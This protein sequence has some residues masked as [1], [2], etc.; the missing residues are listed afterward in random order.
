MEVCS[1]SDVMGVSEWVGKGGGCLQEVGTIG[2]ERALRPL[3]CEW[4]EEREAVR[5]Q[6]RQL[7]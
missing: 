5:A 7:V 3:A 4:Q 1:L 6:H 2:C